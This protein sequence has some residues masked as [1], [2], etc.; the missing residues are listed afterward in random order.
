MES[1]LPLLN[2]LDI[3]TVNNIYKLQA[4]KFIH[5]WHRKHLPN[6]F[7]NYFQY[8]REVHSYNTRHASQNNLYKV[9]HRTNIGKQKISAMATDL[10]QQLPLALKE[11]NNFTFPKKLKQ[12]LL[13]N[14]S[15]S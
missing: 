13:Q 4:L 3:L 9:R 12:Y 10:W 8:V 15:H 5:L 6:I 14:Q 7:D 2:L 11:Q 1:A